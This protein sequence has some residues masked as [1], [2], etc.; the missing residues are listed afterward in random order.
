MMFWEHE[1][2]ILFLF[3]C[4]ILCQGVFGVETEEVKAVNS[5]KS[6]SCWITDTLRHGVQIDNQT[7]SLTFINTSSE[8]GGRYKL[9]IFNK[10]LMLSNKEF[11]VTFYEPLPIPAVHQLENSSCSQCVLQCSVNVTQATLSWYNG[12]RLL[13]SIN[14]SDVNNNICVHL[15][16]DV[17]DYR[18]VVN[19]SI[20]NQTKPLSRS[21]LCQ[22]CAEAGQKR[23]HTALI[24]SI[25]M[26]MVAG[27]L[28]VW[29]SRK[30]LQTGKKEVAH[31]YKNGGTGGSAD[32][33]ENL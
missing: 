25:M 8:L 23:G 32:E 11:N 14:V 13:S 33:E 26:V 9:Q 19:N 29:R 18:C 5:S 6:P 22:S 27:A 21:E 1:L 28:I 10:S 20:S 24:F 17:N 2:M 12:N 7:G 15:E 31:S 30:N 3:L 16:G 4:T